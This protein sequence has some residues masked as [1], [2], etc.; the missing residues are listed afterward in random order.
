MQ[1]LYLFICLSFFSFVTNAQLVFNEN[2][3]GY[4][5]GDLG[6]QGGW[7]GAVASPDV[8]VAAASPLLYTGY[9]SGAN[10]ITVAAAN[11][12]DPSKGF[13]ASISTAAGRTTFLS[14]V[15][16]V[17]SAE[18]L[19]SDPAFSIVLR[20]TA[21]PDLPLRFHIAEDNGAPSTIEFGIAIGGSIVQYTS[22]NFQ[23]GVTYLIVIRYD[24]FPS[25]GP[26]FPTNDDAY[27]WVNPANFP[28]EPLT[29]AATTG[30]GSTVING[31]EIDFGSVLNALQIFQSDPDNSP[32]AA[33]DAFRVG[34]GATS[35]DAWT[36]LNSTQ[37]PVPVTMKSFKAVKDNNA[38]KV[39]WEVGTEHNVAGYEIE[40]SKDGSHFE[41]I[42]FVAAEGKTNYSYS[43]S[44][45][46]PGMNLYRIVT[47]DNDR[48]LKY[49]SI[50]SINGRK[51]LYLS[52]FPNPT[53]RSLMVQ[54]QEVDAPALLRVISL[55]GR[56][57]KQVRLALYSVQ[58]NLD[59][60][61]LGAGNY[62]LEYSTGQKKI[63]TTF[64]KK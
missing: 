28:A 62:I 42:G 55:D 41:P 22:G 44:R 34:H 52:R 46:L 19:N 36:N 6:I 30:T 17:T 11:G 21:D 33:Y 15:V 56:V 23:Y 49:S 54:H 26:S 43:D 45:P 32:G 63:S 47:I 35:A 4:A 7:T 53:T 14:F 24:V 1:K 18:E 51:D 58:T 59:V 50:V 64:I 5:I 37:A 39:L 9:G 3:T 20:N 61:G 38:V 25:P 40:R 16:R 60:T 12:R 2:F 10:Y 48:R 27:L 57:V 31:T 13:S 29:S 8:Q